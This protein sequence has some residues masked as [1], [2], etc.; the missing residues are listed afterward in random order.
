MSLFAIADTHLSFG[1]DKP[2]DIFEGWQNFEEKLQKNW[3]AVVTEKDTV[4]ITGDISWGMKLEDTL[5][6]FRFLDSLNGTKIVMKGL[7][8]V[9]HAPGG[10]FSIHS[11]RRYLRHLPAVRRG[12]ISRR[13]PA[14]GVYP[15]CQ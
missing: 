1:T 15:R 5:E 2:M 10:E 14:S 12:H 11:F 13:R 9:R 3:N 8:V 6:D 4:V 7:V